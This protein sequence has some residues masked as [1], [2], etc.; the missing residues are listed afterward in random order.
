M[1]PCRP[2]SREGSPADGGAEPLRRE[3]SGDSF[4]DWAGLVRTMSDLDD[5]GD[6][7]AA[8]VKQLKRVRP[9]TPTRTL[10]RREYP[11]FSANHYRVL[12]HR[13]CCA[14]QT[15]KL[16]PEMLCL[17]FSTITVNPHLIPRFKP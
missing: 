17:G 4:A 6:D 9:P 11:K 14:F 10:T 16:D 7:M 5:S 15:R 12:P 3:A 8:R 1:P 13:W 2:S